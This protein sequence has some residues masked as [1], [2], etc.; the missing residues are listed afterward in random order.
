MAIDKCTGVY[1]IMLDPVYN[2]NLNY[3]YVAVENVAFFMFVNNF[4]ISEN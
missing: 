2:G 3:V 4:L 1:I